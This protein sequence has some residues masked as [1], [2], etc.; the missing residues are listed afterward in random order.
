MHNKYVLIKSDTPDAFFFFFYSVDGGRFYYMVRRSRAPRRPSS[1]A[2]ERAGTGRNG[3]RGGFE[4]GGGPGSQGRT[5]WKHCRAVA[6]GGTDEP[7]EGREGRWR[8]RVCARSALIGEDAR[9][10]EFELW[11]TLPSH[12][13]RRFRFAYDDFAVK[14]AGA[15]R[16]RSGG[17]SGGVNVPNSYETNGVGRRTKQKIIKQYERKTEENRLV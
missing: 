14:P 16:I 6:K 2:A 12:T 7:A 11:I 1:G 5:R 9:A 10:A 3:P 4:R 15:K 17:D 8:R 13:E